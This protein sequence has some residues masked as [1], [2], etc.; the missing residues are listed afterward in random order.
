MNQKAPSYLFLTWLIGFIEGDGSLI[1]AKRGDLSFVITQDTRDIQVLNMIKK[2]LNLGKVIKQGKTTSRYIIQD[3]KGFY[4]I[5][6]LLNKNLV[7]YS[8]IMSLNFFIL[9]LNKYNQKGI[10]KYPIINF[11]LLSFNANNLNLDFRNK[12]KELFFN[13]AVKP[14]LQDA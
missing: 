10:I 14:T 3:K 2:N 12:N 8:K 13:Y 11:N 4:L 9:A 5:A 1:I 6:I 7:T